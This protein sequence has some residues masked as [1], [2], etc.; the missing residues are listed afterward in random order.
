M[1]RL[2]FS[3]LILCISLTASAQIQLPAMSPLQEMTQ[4]IGLS[5]VSLSYSRPSL[6]G[7][8][9][10]GPQ[11]ILLPGE[12]WRTGANAVTKI[13]C[14][15]DLEINGQTLSKGAYVLLTTPQE[16]TWTFHFYPYEKRAYTHFLDKVPILEFTVESQKTAYS[17]ETLLIHFDAI[18]LGTANFVLQWEH[19]RVEVP[20]KTNEHQAILSN[21]DKVLK[22]PSNFAYFQAALYLHE[23]KTDLPLALTYIRKA[24]QDESALFFQVYRE[25]LIL[26]DLN[27][28][29][30][31]IKAAKRAKEL[32]EK[33]GNADLAR[34][35]QRMIEELSF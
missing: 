6:R 29:E 2:I 9:L 33:A 34:L 24:T 3:T 13:E 7:R 20:I 5:S 18:H 14:S 12:K 11:G 15:K 28:V 30:E 22:G 35:S 10:F 27:K 8:S 17:T 4:K 23:T 21:I 25:A 26:K 16:N 1:F 31:A 32:S 19:Y